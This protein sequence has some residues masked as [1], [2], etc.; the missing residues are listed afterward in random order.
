M[1]TLG[2][3]N[4]ESLEITRGSNTGT[5]VGQRVVE[6]R[7][8]LGQL[9]KSIRTNNNELQK[10]R[11]N[12]A[13]NAASYHRSVSTI[14]TRLQIGTTP[15]NPQ[16]FALLQTAQNNLQTL[17]AN[18]SA[19]DQL[20]ARVTA[21]A[22]MTAHLLDSI[23][24]SYAISGAV[25]E[26]HRQLRILENEA[27]QTS[28]LVNSLLSEVDSDASLQ[29]Q[30]VEIANHHLASLDPAIKQ[31]NFG[32]TIFAPIR[33]GNFHQA[34]SAQPNQM[35]HPVQPVQRRQ[36]NQP[37]VIA[38]VPVPMQQPQAQQF[39]QQPQAQQFT[40]PGGN[41]APRPAMDANRPIVAVTGK[42]S[43][44]VKFAHEN[45][46]YGDGLRNA[47]DFALSSRPNAM[48]DVVAVT[49]A[50][51]STEATQRYASKVFSDIVGMGVPPDRIALSG[52]TTSSVTVPEVQVFV[53]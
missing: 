40:T 47:I 13:A 16:M 20:S 32:G 27:S 18:A 3:T 45:V 48:F 14:E 7:N 17:S 29:R 44:A 50:T 42:P 31:G 28:I 43:F 39:Q 6:F 2:T 19:L 37:M 24:A 51:G 23:R 53:R 34:Q 9:Q 36:L 12:V 26:D 30:S 52:R 4:F 21:D 38:P 11:T 33:R 46:D 35:A 15:G 8:S 22:A 5:V 41:L 10:I 1:P 49:P 25:D